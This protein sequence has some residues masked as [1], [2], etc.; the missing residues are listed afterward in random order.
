[1]AKYGEPVIRLGRG[2]QLRGAEPFPERDM[3]VTEC[4]FAATGVRVLAH[5]RSFVLYTTVAMSDF[6]EI[7]YTPDHTPTNV[8]LPE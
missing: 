3:D 1:M 8:K 7:Y 2:G 5:T 4:G 6:M